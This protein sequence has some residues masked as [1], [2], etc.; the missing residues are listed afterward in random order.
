MTAVMPP[1]G[2]RP[3][4]RHPGLV[5]EVRKVLKIAQEPISLETPTGS[6]A[7][8]AWYNKNGGR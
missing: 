2:A 7:S 4:R 3:P 5:S 6:M 8:E 1:R